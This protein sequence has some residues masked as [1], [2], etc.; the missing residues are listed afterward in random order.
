MTTIL[1]GYIGF[2]IPTILHI[3]MEI[4]YV[5][6]LTDVAGNITITNNEFELNHW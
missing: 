1:M 6:V 3:D 4:L 2:Y 5:K